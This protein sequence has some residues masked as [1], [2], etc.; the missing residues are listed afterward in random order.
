MTRRRPSCTRYSTWKVTHAD[1]FDALQKLDADT[2]DAIVT[3]PPY[4]I[5]FNGIEWDRPARLDPAAGGKRRHSPTEDPLYGFQQFSREWSH[6]CMLSLKPGSHLAAFAAP[7]TAHRLTCGLEEAASKSATCSCG[8]K[9]RATP[10]R[11]PT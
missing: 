10:A 9:A 7:R 8:F 2:V 3:D 11:A 5:N 4:G 1:C 6:A